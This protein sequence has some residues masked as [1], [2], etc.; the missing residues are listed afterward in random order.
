MARI[1]NS[2]RQTDRATRSVLRVPLTV[3]VGV[4]VFVQLGQ[5]T[6]DGTASGSPEVA[7]D[8]LIVSSGPLN[9]PWRYRIIVAVSEVYHHLYAQRIVYGPEG[10]EPEIASAYS[11]G[12]ADLGGSNY[13][14]KMVQ[15]VEWIDY[16]HVK[17]RINDRRD[18]TLELGDSQYT[19]ECQE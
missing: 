10:S 13:S 2:S 15:G 19:I 8:V 7:A 3:L 1:G 6:A 4:L 17:I 16:R 18:C 9:G 14:V 12:D 5:A 11:V